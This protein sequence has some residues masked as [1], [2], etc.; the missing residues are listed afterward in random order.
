M[1]RGA[2]TLSSPVVDSLATQFNLS[3][4]G[5]LVTR[6]NRWFARFGV[7]VA[8]VFLVISLGPLSQLFH[9]PH[10]TDLCT[11]ACAPVP[12][13]QYYA[14]W[15]VASAILIGGAV[16]IG[17]LSRIG[18]APGPIRVRVTDD[19][20]LFYYTN[21]KLRQVKWPTDKTTLTI[22]DYQQVIP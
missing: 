2:L 19:G 15:A 22:L 10:A 3:R 12:V 5:F 4:E 18:V 9:S 7:G 1:L 16:G 14:S 8:I 13:S 21:G 20:L 6:V 17:L 11:V